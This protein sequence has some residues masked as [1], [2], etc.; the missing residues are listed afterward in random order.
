MHIYENTNIDKIAS[1]NKSAFATTSTYRTIKARKVIITAGYAAV[2]YIGEGITKLSRSYT[3]VTEPAK[4]FSGRAD[5]CLIRDPNSNYHL[6]TTPDG[7]FII[8]GEAIDLGCLPDIDWVL[9]SKAD[10][11]RKRLV[12]MFPQCEGSKVTHKFSGLLAD[13]KDGLPYI[14][15]YKSMPNC[16]FL[17]G[18]GASGILYD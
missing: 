13:T 1:D 10:I 5:K 15:E 6:R 12:A 2:K 9:D 14:G 16:Y 4:N 7:R 8:G 3:I 11:L 18:F 17:L